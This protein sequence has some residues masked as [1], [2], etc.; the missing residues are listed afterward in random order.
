MKKIYFLFVILVAGLTSCQ[1]DDSDV[2]SDGTGNRGS[3]DLKATSSDGV[4]AQVGF[5]EK[6]DGSTDITVVL[7]KVME[8]TYPVNILSNSVVEGGEVEISLNPI[9]GSSRTSVTNITSLSFEELINYDGHIN[10][11][12]SSDAQNIVSQGD[13]GDNKLTGESIEYILASQAI[14]DISGTAT[15]EQRRSGATLLTIALDGTPDGASHPAHIHTN[16]AA[17]TGGIVIDLKA[18][19]GTSG[20]SMTHIESFND[21]TAVDYSDLL[22]YDGYINVHLSADNLATLVAQSDIGANELTGETKEYV[23]GSV[24]DPD[25]M[26]SATFSQRKDGSAL[27]E[28]NLEG[29]TDGNSHPAHIHMNSAA[30]TG[31]IAIDL[32]EV[33]GATG[34]SATQVE[35]FNDGTSI[36]YEGLLEYDG[37][38]NVH[39]SLADITTLLAQ[40]DIGVNEL[41]G[42]T[43]EYALGSVSNPDISG[44]ATFSE[45]M[46]GTTLVELNLEG[47][48]DGNAHPA[49][50]HMNTAAETGDIVIDLKDVDGAT[51]MSATQV[52][53]FNDDTAVEYA[54]LLEYDGYINVHESSLNITTLLA[55]GDIGQNEL[56]GS[57]Q[58]YILND[59][60]NPAIS[61]VAS[62]AERVNGETLV[63]L[64]LNGTSSGSLFPAHIHAGSVAEAP[65]D[66]VI[67]LSSVVGA[68]GLSKTNVAA[69]N[70]DTPI[71]YTEMLAIDGYI[72]AHLSADDLGVLVAQGNVGVNDN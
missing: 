52:E 66:I 65:G 43:K 38:I 12:S 16:S 30:E 70:D 14:D 64:S 20:M 44:T 47:T 51:G 62:F 5:V 10:I 50:I 19:N 40:G 41:T 42:N 67:T 22:N 6:N 72:N 28:L 11:Q 36:G 31:A 57:K 56:T 61:G 35:A 27:V 15:L 71:T 60:S 29:T 54:A 48:S 55:Q 69:Y 26:G 45:R 63:T 7:L 18:V 2:I 34:R 4:N 23:L 49:H 59:V 24:S 9:D 37:Y 8:G 25:I 68:T 21:G 53:A 33:D 13:I 46:D 58:S 39:A 1:D 3:Y 32:K 17:E